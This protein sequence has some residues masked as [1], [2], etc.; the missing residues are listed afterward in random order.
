MRVTAILA[1]FA[2]ATMPVY[3]AKP[4]AELQV[5]LQNAMLAYTD[6]ILLDGSYIYL[7]LK[8]DRLS[9]V[10]PANAHPFVVTLGDNY[11][12]CLFGIYNR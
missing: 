10:Y 6:S 11:F 4:S 3:A 9:T 12:V 2:M 7:D 8:K 1:I 5:E